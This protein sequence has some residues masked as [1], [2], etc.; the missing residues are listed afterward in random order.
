MATNGKAAPGTPPRRPKPAPFTPSNARGERPAIVPAE[1][2]DMSFFTEFTTYF[3]Y[4]LLIRRPAGLW[5]RSREAL[6]ATLKSNQ[7]KLAPPSSR[8]P[9]TGYMAASSTFLLGPSVPHSPGSPFKKRKRIR[10]SN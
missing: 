3:A 4:T 7:T 8:E 2:I 10:H 1:D 5:G 9:P 6:F